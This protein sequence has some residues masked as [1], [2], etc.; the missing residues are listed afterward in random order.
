VIILSEEPTTAPDIID[1][2]MESPLPV[3]DGKPFSR[4]EIYESR[5]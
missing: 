3:N 1:Q 2:L 4:D 5:I